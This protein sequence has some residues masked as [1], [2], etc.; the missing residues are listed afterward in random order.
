[1]YKWQVDTWLPLSPILLVFKFLWNSPLEYGLD[2][3]SNEQ[4]TAKVNEQSTA[5]V[6]A[7]HFQDY[8]IKA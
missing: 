7:G 5:K 8:V 3:I 2:L 6:M 4:N 1:M